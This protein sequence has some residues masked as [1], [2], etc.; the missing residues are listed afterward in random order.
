MYYSP[1][2]IGLDPFENDVDLYSSFFS[3]FHKRDLPVIREM[4]FNFLWLSYWVPN[5]DHKDFLKLAESQQFSLIVSFRPSASSTTLLRNKDKEKFELLLNELNAY[6]HIVKIINIDEPFYKTMSKKDVDEYIELASEF[7]SIIREK[8]NLP[9]EIMVGLPIDQRDNVIANVIDDVFI[10]SHELWSVRIETHLVEDLMKSYMK[11]LKKDETQDR[12]PGKPLIPMIR[13]DNYQNEN[14]SSSRRTIDC[15][16]NNDTKQV[17]RTKEI[18]K[19]ILQYFRAGDGN[20]LTVKGMAIFEYSDEWWR[21]IQASVG[22]D[23]EGCP[24][25]NPY[26]HTGCGVLL[27]KGGDTLVLEYL[28]YY[29]IIDRPFR[30]CLKEKIVAQLLRELFDRSI[31]YPSSKYNPD[32]EYCSIVPVYPLNAMLDYFNITD[33]TKSQ[34]NF[35]NLYITA[36]LSV[37]T[38]LLLCILPCPFFCHPYEFCCKSKRDFNYANRKDNPFIGT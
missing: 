19:S 24:N 33:P 5:G 8:T 11:L 21:G 28:G 38:F 17:E 26:A 20:E 1:C 36:L 23:I 16:T 30:Y 32:A 10:G 27:G 15:N 22:R 2:P 18:I 13:V 7:K 14:C 3:D 4:G 35:L 37:T 9:L 6:T 34:Q 12:G 31:G 25:A 29:K